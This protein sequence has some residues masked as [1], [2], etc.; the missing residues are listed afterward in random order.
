MF[1]QK[2]MLIQLIR[3]AIGDAAKTEIEALLERLDAL[4]A[5]HFETLYRRW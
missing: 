4:S 3:F 1:I 5:D 2:Q